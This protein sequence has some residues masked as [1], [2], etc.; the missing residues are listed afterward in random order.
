[1]NMAEG[2]PIEWNIGLSEEEK[3]DLEEMIDQFQKGAIRNP[4]NCRFRYDP[5][6]DRYHQPKAGQLVQYV[7]E[8]GSTDQTV[9]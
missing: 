8:P 5:A 9:V 7:S 6:A 4:R 1:M 2:S 3:N